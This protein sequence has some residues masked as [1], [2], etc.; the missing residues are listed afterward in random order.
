MNTYF[1]IDNKGQTLIRTYEVLIDWFQVTIFPKKDHKFLSQFLL[2]DN[3]ISSDRIIP[4]L[5]KDLFNVSS[6]DIIKE[7]YGLNG[8]DIRYSYKNIS[9]MYHSLRDDMGINILLT[10]HGCR[11]FEELG[12]S[13]YELFNRLNNFEINF[14]RIDIAIDDF[15]NKNFSI[16][17]LNKYIDN[18]L[19]CS[20][21]KKVF[22]CGEK[23]INDCEHLGEMIQFGSK[24]SDVEITFYNKYLE[25]ENAGYI[26]DNDIKYWLRTELRFR[27]ERAEEIF[28]KIVILDDYMSLVKQVLFYYI[29]FKSPTSKDKNKSRKETVKWWS[30]FLED[31]SKLKLCSR[32]SERSITKTYNWLLQSVSKSQL[33]VYMAMLPNISLD[34]MSTD[35][36]FEQLIKGGQKITDKDL[37]YIN[38]F[39][40]ANKMIPI[41][42]GQLLD[43]LQDLK[44]IIIL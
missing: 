17:L 33:M 1:D 15:T 6:A 29:D 44:D 36:L 16:P 4:L 18:D 41:T 9:L 20:R 14:N 37:I 11:D 8:Y 32:S 28:K 31:C 26:I 7:N 42:K 25:R 19:C 23:K 5:F 34:S 3:F 22:Y 2:Y 30:I 12:I 24:A 27:H 13:W 35:L 21:F 43:Y 39:R 40:K 10:G 38:D